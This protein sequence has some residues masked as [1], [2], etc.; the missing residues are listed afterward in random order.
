MTR[1]TPL[2]ALGDTARAVDIASLVKGDQTDLCNVCR[3]NPRA[4]GGKLT[5]CL[6]CLRRDVDVERQQR[7][8]RKARAEQE[9]K[10]K[11]PSAT[12][13]CRSCK[14]TKPL[15]SFGKHRLAKDGHRHDCRVCVRAECI[16]RKEKTDQQ[17]ELDRHNAAQ[18][19]RR[20]ANRA[21][22]RAWSARN[23]MAARARRLLR[24][25]VKSG[26][27]QVADQC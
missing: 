3:T 19:H 9:A 11:A 13:A 5:R 23:P 22:V 6:Q 2:K 8:A 16:K 18:P 1:A 15:A 17:R 10:A 27:V 4:A 7:E 24:Q 26:K 12:K 20:A 25:A 14:I 21:S